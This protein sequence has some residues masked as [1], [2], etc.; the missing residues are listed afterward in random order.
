VTW[1]HA[2]W[3]FALVLACAAFAWLGQGP[4]V[5]DA[6]WNPAAGLCLFFL[7]RFGVRHWPFVVLAAQAG[8]MIA[9]TGS[10][11]LASAATALMM[12]AAYAWMAHA[13]RAQTQ[14]DSLRALTAPMRV[15]ALGT[16]ILC[17]AAGA[18][19]GWGSPAPVS[20][21][22]S[23]VARDWIAELNGI[24]VLVP[25]LLLHG[26]ARPWRWRGDIAAFAEGLAQAASIALVLWAVFA[27]AVIYNV[28]FFSIVFLPLIW[29]V[30]RWGLAG[31]SLALVAFQAGILIGAATAHGTSALQLQ[32]LTFAL[33]AT[34]PTLG[35]VVT[36]R[37]RVEARLEE[38]QAAL[39]QALQL[40]SVGEMTSALAH[41]LSQPVSALS[42][43]LGACA[44]LATDDSNR[45][46]LQDTLRKANAEASRASDVV[47]RLRDFYRRGAVEIV[48]VAPMA[49]IESA[50]RIAQSRAQRSGAQVIIRSP[51]PLPRVAVDALQVETALLNVLHNAID[52]LGDMPAPRIVTVSA[53]LSA[54]GVAIVVTD[55][56][57]GVDPQI[58][59]RLFE[60]FNTSK[61]SGMGMG[62]A[63][64]R[65]LLRASGGDIVLNES[66][67]EG[68]SFTIMLPLVRAHP[69]R[70]H[71]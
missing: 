49:L 40:A 52:A 69:G 21:F 34:G 66:D 3:G 9:G 60:P 59:A 8:A 1:R 44:V 28:R 33:C 20:V 5:N 16:L 14:L 22:V 36:Q 35:A 63:I 2:G 50:V 46:L 7:L 25:A 17:I 64:S 29:I 30:V 31:S 68:A 58:A 13:L 37:K 65:S 12:T 67:G 23:S 62:L 32:L 42:R 45:E 48:T 19:H 6:L 15:V 47:V 54:P 11:V 18:W 61:P 57:P 24:M 55:N 70:S 10:A 38:K 43:Y 41:E 4:F 26:Q 27:V 56:G 53:G 39:N 51:H 71:G